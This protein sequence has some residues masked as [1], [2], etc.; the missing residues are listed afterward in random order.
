MALVIISKTKTNLKQKTERIKLFYT[1]VLKSI[2]FGS[3]IFFFSVDP[4]VA[5][6]FGDAG[7]CLPSA[8]R[9]LLAH[10]HLRIDPQHHPVGRHPQV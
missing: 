4:V 8:P 2:I 1:T 3:E 10:R 5:M 9:T 6:A 7:I